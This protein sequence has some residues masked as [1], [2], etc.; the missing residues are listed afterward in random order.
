MPLISEEIAINSE[1]MCLSSEEIRII[2][3]EIPQSSER[4]TFIGGNNRD[5]WG[6]NSENE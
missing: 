6:N 2:V 1:I 4:I 5:Y 3:E